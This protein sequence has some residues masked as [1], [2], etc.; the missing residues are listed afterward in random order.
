M[1][2]DWQITSV[3]WAP[4][5]GDATTPGYDDF[6]NRLSQA[7]VPGSPG[8]PPEVTLSYGEATNRITTGGYTYDLNGNITA[9]PGI[10]GIGWDVFDRMSG[11]SVPGT[12][13]TFKYDAFG[14]RMDSGTYPYG[15]HIY[16][17]DMGGRL[18]AEYGN[19]YSGATPTKKYE[20]FAGQQLGQYKDRVGSVRN[21]NGGIGSHYYP[22][23]EEI[24]STANDRYKFAETFRDADS[25]LDYALNR[26]YAASIGRFL[27]VDAAQADPVRPQS[28]NR[29]AYAENDP[30][31]FNDPT[32][33]YIKAPNGCFYFAGSLV[34]AFQPVYSR[35]RGGYGPGPPDDA[36]DLG[37][38][39]WQDAP[40]LQL[41][42][43]A[44]QPSRMLKNSLLVE[45][46][47]L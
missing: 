5:R 41:A 23:G 18:L 42:T 39:R 17:Y 43:K 30:A 29:Y 11:T 1:D 8:T 27:S 32:G 16:F 15:H 31:N 14:R 33:T 46:K 38:R 24:T 37:E 36:I 19:V 22:F 40:I 12:T 45:T 21:T 13:R 9:M 20:Y 34:C 4:Q 28:F 2:S 44:Q 26:Y 7:K 3:N 35:P 10:T 25:G 47:L 6:G